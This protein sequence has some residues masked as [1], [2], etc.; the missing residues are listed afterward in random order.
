MAFKRILRTAR[1]ALPTIIGAT[2]GSAVPGVGT[3][4]GASLGAG[5]GSLA[6]G[7]SIGKA[8]GQGALAYGGARVLGGL[9]SPASSGGGGIGLPSFLR[10]TAVDRIIPSMDDISGVFGRTAGS[11]VSGG[12][13]PTQGTG[14]IGSVGRAASGISDA[15]PN[16]GLSDI[17]GSGAQV[18][19]AS[20]AP[21]TDP[22][23]QLPWLQQGAQQATDAVA[24]GF[25]SF[26][27]NNQG[28]LSAA[29]LGAQALM[30]DRESAMERN[31]RDSAN[32]A[33]GY[34]DTFINAG[35]T[36]QLPQGLSE[37]IM[38]GYEAA[39]AAIRNKYAGLGLSGST[40][41]MQ[42]LNNL[43]QRLATQKFDASMNL[44]NTGF[45]AAG[46]ADATYRA[47]LQNEMNNDIQLMEAIARLSGA[48]GYSAAAGA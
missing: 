33:R 36:G 29:G 28:L 30:G 12:I 32:R 19:G 34:A 15:I 25:E 35:T 47:L 21:V 24:P 17:F 23:A 38:Q 48:G 31:L 37:G 4:L 16:V 27:R 40:M 10:G 46:V 20:A 9:S 13:G 2:I 45:Q 44:A 14:V 3:A 7:D 5:A 1:R 43:E 26:L 11:P 8:F 39:K 18:P 22:S 6:R 42:E 41:E